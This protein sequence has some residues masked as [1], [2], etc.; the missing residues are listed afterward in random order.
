MA[1]MK[2]I[3]SIYVLNNNKTTHLKS[4]HTPGQ[5]NSRMLNKKRTTTHSQAS[6]HD[7]IHEI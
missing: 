7:Q 6:L 5:S 3:K 2:E 4:C 1:L